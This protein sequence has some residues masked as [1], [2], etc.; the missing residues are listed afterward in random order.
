MKMFLVLSKKFC[1]Y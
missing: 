1:D